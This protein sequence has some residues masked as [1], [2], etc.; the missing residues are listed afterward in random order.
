LDFTTE[1]EGWVGRPAGV[2]AQQDRH[3]WALDS[4]KH[5]SGIGKVLVIYN[6][7]TCHAGPSPALIDTVTSSLTALG[8]EVGIESITPKQIIIKLLMT[9]YLVR[10]V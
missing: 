6:S 5:P 10:E 2:W 7:N 3:A 9:I 4:S 1:T 8:F